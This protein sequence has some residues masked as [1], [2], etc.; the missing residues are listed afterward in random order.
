MPFKQEEHTKVNFKLKRGVAEFMVN[1]FGIL[2]CRWMDSKDFTVVSNC[3]KATVHSVKRK[4][5]DGNKIDVSCP[6]VIA[7][8]NESVGNV[9]LLDQKVTI[10]DYY[11]KSAKWLKKVYYRLVLVTVVNTNKRTKLLPFIVNLAEQL[12]MTRRMTAK[13]VRKTPGSKGP[14]SK[15]SKLMLNIGDHM[16]EERQGR[17]RL[18]KI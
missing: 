17:R 1:E 2:A 12:V 6:N 15:R 11:K 18:F 5:K 14:R 8:Y 9:D 4:Q 3:H 10:C 16:P 13:V 7:L